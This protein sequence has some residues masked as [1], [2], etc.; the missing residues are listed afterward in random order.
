MCRI[1]GTLT[2]RN[3]AMHVRYLRWVEGHLGVHCMFWILVIGPLVLWFLG[4]IANIGGEAID[5]L[6]VVPA[7]TL[8]FELWPKKRAAG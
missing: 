5:L 6:L 2:R 3:E 8:L 4:A 7:G 1:N